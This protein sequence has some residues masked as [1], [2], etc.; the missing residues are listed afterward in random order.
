MRLVN[1]L[2]EQLGGLPVGDDLHR[3]TGYSYG[4]LCYQTELS[5]PAAGMIPSLLFSF[6]RFYFPRASN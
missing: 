5:L 6:V 4:G 2:T 1:P 3:L